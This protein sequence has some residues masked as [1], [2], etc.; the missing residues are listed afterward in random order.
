MIG[1]V[2]IIRYS[3]SL[4][5]A[6]CIGLFFQNTS[7][8]MK[9]H[10]IEIKKEIKMQGCSICFPP[11]NP[12]PHCPDSVVLFS[13][14]ELLV[15]M[16]KTHTERL[17]KKKFLCKICNV[18]VKNMSI[19]LQKNDHCGKLRFVCPVANCKQRNSS[20]LYSFMNHIS[21]HKNAT[22]CPI[23]KHIKDCHIKPGYYV[24]NYCDKSFSSKVILQHHLAAD[25][26]EPEN[27]FNI[28][29]KTGAKK[30]KKKRMGN[31]KKKKQ[32]TI[33]SLE[34]SQKDELIEI[35]ELA[36]FPLDVQENIFG[37]NQLDDNNEWFDLNALNQNPP[38]DDPIDIFFN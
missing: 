33:K 15:H 28:V 16:K 21:L 34:Q 10:S 32:P 29:K 17:G 23:I 38:F 13:P 8:A 24:C 30:I 1:V 20:R 3:Y 25:H 18:I 5:I 36:N 19:H 35:K 7:V 12:C 9:L 2:K 22:E 31:K 27:L 14:K 4:C 37:N 26:D 6:V 11:K